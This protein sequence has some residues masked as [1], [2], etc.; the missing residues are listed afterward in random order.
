MPRSP[1]PTTR[2]DMSAGTSARSRIS[3]RSTAETESR[4]SS[5]EPEPCPRSSCD[6]AT[7]ICGPTP[8]ADLTTERVESSS[9]QSVANRKFLRTVDEIGFR[10]SRLAGKLYRFDAG[11]QF[12]PQDPHLHLGQ[13]LAE[14]DMRAVPEREVPVRI[15]VDT[16]C[17][18]V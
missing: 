8:S 13:V 3:T 4:F 14:A 16:K 6:H 11:Q 18:W 12:F 17:V 2:A 1:E 5:S 10:E 9:R 15:A 7:F